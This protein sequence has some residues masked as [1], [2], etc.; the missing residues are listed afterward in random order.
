MRIGLFTDTYLPDVNGV[1]S[2]IETLRTAL[3]DLGHEVYVVC[4]KASLE[5]A[6]LEDHILRLPGVEAKM[7][8]GYSLTGPVHLHALK[9][10][11]EMNLDVIHAHTEFGAGIFARIVS[12]QLS[13][14]LVATY[15]TFYEDYTHYLNVFKLSIAEPPLK[16]VTRAF[17]KFFGNFCQQL[18]VPT[19]K[20]KQRL[21]EYG[22]NTK[23]TIIPTGLDFSN[24]ASDEV[25]DSPFSTKEFTM[26]YIGRLA[27]E[28]SVDVIIQAIHRLKQ[29][30]QTVHCMIVG[31]GP[32]RQKLE[33][34][35]EQYHL[36]EEVYMAGKIVHS[37]VVKYYNYADGFVS[38]SMSETQGMTFIEAMA[39][40][41]QVLA[42]DKVALKEV[43]IDEENGYY[44]TDY[45]DLATKIMMLKNADEGKKE[46][47]KQKCQQIV[48]QY[49]PKTFG[50][51]VAQVYQDAID[52]YHQIASISKVKLADKEVKI[53][54]STRQD[55]TI[56][57]ISYDDYLDQRYHKGDGLEQKQLDELASLHRYWYAFKKAAR[58]VQSMD[59]TEK[60]IRSYLESL[61]ALEEAQ[62]DQII[63]YFKQRG[64]LSD[65]A[66]IESQS[67]VDQS[68]LL[69]KKLT[70]RKLVK[71]G[72]PQQT[73]QL[74]LDQMD[75]SLEQERG[76]LKASQY[77]KSIHDKSHQETIRYLKEKLYLDGYEDASQ[78]VEQLALAY[79]VEKEREVLYRQ[80]IKARERYQRKYEGKQLHQACFKYLM[81]KGFQAS[82]IDEVLQKIREDDECEN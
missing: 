76:L 58:K 8:Y 43:L 65:Q 53:T 57:T 7:M 55:D 5:K 49:S 73:V 13:I 18:I 15:H 71:R 46:M 14:P 51:K 10:V 33:E 17:S 56:Y 35:I 74:M 30:N 47:M 36:Q 9:I 19:V 54:V 69:G 3:V 42:K 20:T 26:I 64:Y 16:M 29:Q 75:N 37:E 70:E 23:M 40:G 50:Q 67:F 44:F 1:V 79:D 28:K 62:I 60:E 21:I 32:D 6:Q 52:N 4:T 77:L 82:L 25:I 45:Q 68:R 27:E 41:K 66:V 80:A 34:M 2:S 12:H 31:D 59:R 39:C 24:F 72:V 22:V 81:S 11:K 48:D 63:D 61:N 78:I 38:A